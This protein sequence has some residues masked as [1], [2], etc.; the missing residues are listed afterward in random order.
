MCG[1]G[2]D[3]IRA[4]DDIMASSDLSDD[5]QDDGEG[6]ESAGLAAG[7]ALELVNTIAADV[8]EGVFEEITMGGV[9]SIRG[10]SLRSKY[11][12]SQAPM[13]GDRSSSSSW[14]P[15]DKVAC[16]QRACNCW[17]EAQGLSF[18]DKPSNNCR[19]ESIWSGHAENKVEVIL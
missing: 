16:Q 5:G 19:R 6:D 12:L 11:K 4:L 13:P 10:Y 9:D 14:D 3:R 15:N 8:D 2:G 17:N 1:Y 18:Q 7:D